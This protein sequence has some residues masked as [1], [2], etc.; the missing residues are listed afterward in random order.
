[1]RTYCC[2]WCGMRANFEAENAGK[3]RIAAL[4]IIRE[5]FDHRVK[6]TEIKVR[7]ARDS[8]EVTP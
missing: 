5:L 3:A 7:L 1:M 2:E 6:L 8:H 4:K